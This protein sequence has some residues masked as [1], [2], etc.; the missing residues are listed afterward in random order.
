MAAASALVALVDV[1][2]IG[3]AAMAQLPARLSAGEAA[4]YRRFARPERARQ[5]LVGR[6]LLRQLA[7]QLLGLPPAAFEVTERPA[8]APLLRLAGG[9]GSVPFFSLSHSGPWVACAVS[10][11]TALGLDI[12]V[13]DPRRDT[14]ALARHVFDGAACAALARLPPEAA[15]DGFYRLWSEKEAR[16]KLGPCVG[17]C[18]LASCIGL[19]H[20]GLAAVLCSA[21]PLSFVPSMVLTTLDGM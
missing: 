3:D 6:V 13:I 7:G 9:Q 11:T 20:P 14:A 18:A 12:E 5:F 15:V 2:V 21:T 17:P 10:A 19:A 4:R 16:Y 1:S 8:L